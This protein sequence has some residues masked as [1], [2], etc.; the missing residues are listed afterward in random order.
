MD[1]EHCSLALTSRSGDD[2]S[3]GSL[4]QLDAVRDENTGR[5]HC[6]GFSP[7]ALEEDQGLGVQGP[8]TWRCLFFL[9]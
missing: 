6:P 1:V 8:Q 9:S 3:L 5:V 2:A 4:G 7:A